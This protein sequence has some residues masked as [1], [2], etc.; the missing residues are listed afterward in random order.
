VT[1]SGRVTDNIKVAS[2]TVNG[3]PAK[4]T[5]GEF[6]LE[7]YLL[8]VGNN[9]IIVKAKDAEGNKATRKVAVTRV[10]R[11]KPGQKAL[12]LEDIE[13]LLESEVSP[14]RVVDFWIPERGIKFQVTEHA[15]SRLLGAGADNGL[16]KSLEELFLR[17]K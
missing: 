14:K 8:R 4:V 16:I 6:T 17:V 12:S 10:L 9:S 2:V 3:R 1:V 15:K 7:R 11:G 5:K 13:D